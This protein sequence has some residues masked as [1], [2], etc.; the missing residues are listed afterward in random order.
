MSDMSVDDLTVG[1]LGG[2]GAQGRGLAL[3]WAAAGL[4]VVLGSRDSDRA[5]QAAAELND[6]LA[7]TA[8]AM[9]QLRDGTREYAGRDVAVAPDAVEQVVAADQL[10][11]ALQQG[12]Q[13]GEGLQ[14]DRLHAARAQQGVRGLVDHDIA[15]AIAPCPGA[16]LTWFHRNHP[17]TLM[18]SHKP[19]SS[20][21]QASHSPHDPT[22]LAPESGHAPH[23]ALP[24]PED[25][26]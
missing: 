4:N 13:H 21:L 26:P 18:R 1:V 25:K 12:Q 15:E 20:L 19:R 14:L 5:G 10:T 24:T 7:A 17:Q 22:G 11:P 8:G 16:A 6:E 9:A 3:R 23:S 2:T